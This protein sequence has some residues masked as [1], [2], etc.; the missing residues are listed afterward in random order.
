M[1]Q[2]TEGAFLIFLIS[3]FHVVEPTLSTFRSENRFFLSLL[4][5]NLE[6]SF[7]VPHL[8]SQAL[9]HRFTSRN[10]TIEMEGA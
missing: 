3:K 1:L 8:H 9:R 5:K 2:G 6:L 7:L 4:F 10:R